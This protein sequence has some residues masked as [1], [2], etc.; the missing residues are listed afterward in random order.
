ML[1]FLSI[2]KPMVH[3]LGNG[4]WLVSN[5]TGM[6]IDECVGDIGKVVKARA[7]ND[8]FCQCSRFKQIMPADFF[9]H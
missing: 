4:F 9:A 1:P 7:C 2:R 3:L 8:G 5:H 6:C